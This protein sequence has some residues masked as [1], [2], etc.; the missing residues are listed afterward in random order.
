MRDCLHNVYSEIVPEP[1]S[2][3]VP[4]SSAFSLNKTHAERHLQ[5]P[6]PQTPQSVA[7]AKRANLIERIEFEL[8]TGVPVDDF[9]RMGV[10]LAHAIAAAVYGSSR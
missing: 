4:S 10:R 6:D 2:S 1:T 3:L 8:E 7:D 5:H 9:G